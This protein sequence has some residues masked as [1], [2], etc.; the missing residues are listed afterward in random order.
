ADNVAGDRLDGGVIVAATGSGATAL[1]CWWSVGGQGESDGDENKGQGA[2][3]RGPGDMSSRPR[4][5]GGM[6][7]P[8][9]TLKKSWMRPARTDFLDDDGLAVARIQL[10]VPRPDGNGRGLAGAH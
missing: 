10:E 4:R 1:R 6:R 5:K 8:Y 2:D 3:H 7:R 9:R